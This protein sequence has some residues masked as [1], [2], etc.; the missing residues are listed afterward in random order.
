[1]LVCPDKGLVRDDEVLVWI[2]GDLGR[3]G[4]SL[5]CARRRALP[6]PVYYRWQMSTDQA[7][8]TD[9]RES[10]K[11]KMTVEGLMPAT[12]YSFRLRAVTRNGPSEWSPPVTIVTH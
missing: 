4:E 11:T 5:V 3:G 8:W 1:M 10:F 2:N 12:V 6:K 7:T 9:L